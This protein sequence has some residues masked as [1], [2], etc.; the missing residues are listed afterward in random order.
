MAKVLCCRDVGVD[1]DFKTSGETVEEVLQAA[2]QHA[3]Q[4][5]GMDAIPPELAGIVQAAIRD[6]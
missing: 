2:A 4:V 1:C 6:E 5:H 3:K